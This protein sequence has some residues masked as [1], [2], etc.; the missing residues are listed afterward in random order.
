M[1]VVWNYIRC[2]NRSISAIWIQTNLVGWNSWIN[3]RWHVVMRMWCNAW[4]S[5]CWN[6]WIRIIRIILMYILSMHTPWNIFLRKTWVGNFYS[7]MFICRKLS[8][9]IY[10]Y[11]YVI[12]VTIKPD[13]LPWSYEL[14][15]GEGMV[16]YLYPLLPTSSTL[17]PTLNK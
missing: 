12:T 5:V 14:W 6:A 3:M 8:V 2:I 16:W 10:M 17:Y 11:T 4:V 7:T 9:L 13:Y 1:G 15:E